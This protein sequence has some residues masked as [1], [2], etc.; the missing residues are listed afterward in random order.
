MNLVPGEEAG[1]RKREWKSE[2]LQR[3]SSL[4]LHGLWH[5]DLY[6]QIMR[7]TSKCK[8]IAIECTALEINVFA[9]ANTCSKAP[10]FL[11]SRVRACESWYSISFTVKIQAIPRKLIYMKASDLLASACYKTV[12]KQ[13]NMCKQLMKQHS[14]KRRTS[15][16][17]QWKQNTDP[18][19]VQEFNQNATDHCSKALHKT[20]FSTGQTAEH[21]IKHFLHLTHAMSDTVS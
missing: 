14:K 15:D 6:S 4:S 9:L 17:L 5:V 20:V 19:Q 18:D 16:V 12:H 13:L 7:H 2:D 3:A 10:L 1:R 8:Q 11:L 21:S